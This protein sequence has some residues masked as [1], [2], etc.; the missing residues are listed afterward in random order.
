MQSKTKK[1][2]FGSDPENFAMTT[3]SGNRSKQQKDMQDWHAQ[4]A[5]DGSGLN[6]KDKHGHDNRRVKPAIKRGEQ[7]AEKHA[8]KT[9]DKVEYYGTRAAVTGASEAAKMGLQQSIGLLLTEFLTASF[10]EIIDVYKRDMRADTQ[11]ASFFKALGGRLTRIA[12]RVAEKWKDALAAF[13]G[14]A[15]SGFLSNLVTMLINMLVTTGKRV[16]R[17]IREGIMAILSALKM[18]L[19]PP[20]GMTRAQAGDAALKLLAIGLTTSLGV[21]AEEVCEKAVTAFF[22]SH[23]PMLAPLASPIASVL[24]A[25]MTGIASALLVY[26]LDRLDIFGVRKQREHA[27]ILRELDRAIAESDQRI[28]EMYD[29]EMRSLDLDTAKLA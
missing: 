23:L 29:A 24:V 3:N 10:D 25:T 16:V 15:I 17:V 20:K 2:D 27:A 9:R 8:P 1:S 12:N 28:N 18:A 11:S 13:K 22:T 26:W 5:T 19:F 4:D 21:M 7:T 6:N 14:G